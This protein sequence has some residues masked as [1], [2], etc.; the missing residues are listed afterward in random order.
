MRKTGFS[1]VIRKIAF[2][3]E[4]SCHRRYSKSYEKYELDFNLGNGLIVINYAVR[5]TQKVS[6]SS[7]KTIS[8]R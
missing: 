4:I 8:E 5:T 6:S 2:Q 7:L 1:F 3:S